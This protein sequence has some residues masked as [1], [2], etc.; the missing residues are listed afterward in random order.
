M[1]TDVEVSSLGPCCVTKEGILDLGVL[2]R[3][4][5]MIREHRIIYG[6][7]SFKN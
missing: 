1:L 6:Q 2:Q 7:N 4:I 5:C 3:H